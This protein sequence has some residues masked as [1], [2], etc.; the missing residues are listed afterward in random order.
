MVMMRHLQ[1]NHPNQIFVSASSDDLSL[2]AAAECQWCRACAERQ[3]CQLDK[4]RNPSPTCSSK[5]LFP[6]HDHALP[7]VAVYML[8][9]INNIALH[10]KRERN[11]RNP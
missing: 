1:D 7:S 4:G 9:E 8:K 3:G 6:S 5:A 2:P 10:K 11:L